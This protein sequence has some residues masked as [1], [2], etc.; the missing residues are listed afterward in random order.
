MFTG[1]ILAHLIG[2]YVLQWDALAI[3]KSK[4]LAGAL[5]HGAVVTA[6][7]L[8][9]AWAL[10]PAWWPWALFI[11]LTH[12][13]VDSLWLLNRRLPPGAQIAPLPRFVLDQILHFTF[14]A[15]ALAWSGYATMPALPVKMLTDMKTY[16]ELTYLLGYVFITMPAWVIVEF[17]VYGLVRAPAPDF[18]PS[19]NRYLGIAERGLIMTFVL[20]GQFI[21][22]PLV[23]LPRLVFEAPKL[24]GNQNAT[25]YLA[26]VLASIAMAVTIGLILRVVCQ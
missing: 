23:A 10:D 9:F 22:V 17:M 19:A 16:R 13:L 2:D 21:L 1:M 4:A 11:G 15:L 14:I 12:T 8:A 25:A 6:V 18:S 26:E 24:Y 5:A 20:Q 7:T 3:W